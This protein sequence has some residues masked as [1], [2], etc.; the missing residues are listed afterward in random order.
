MI[1]YPIRLTYDLMAKQYGPFILIWS[2]END[3]IPYWAFQLFKKEC[4]LNHGNIKD[5]SLKLAFEFRNNSNNLYILYSCIFQQYVDYCN[6]SSFLWTGSA[7][8]Q[9]MSN[10]VIFKP[11][12]G[13][14]TH[15][16]LLSWL[17]VDWVGF[18]YS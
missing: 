10:A 15:E 6:R 17:L 4:N 1:L 11:V 5:V 9:Q 7:K 12:I 18:S 2:D 16:D 3:L 8:Y 13:H 14:Y